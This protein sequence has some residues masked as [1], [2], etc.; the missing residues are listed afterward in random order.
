M[1]TK[2]N[3]L[4][5]ALATALVCLGFGGIVVDCAPT[6]F[7]CDGYSTCGQAGASAGTGTSGAGNAGESTGGLPSGGTDSPGG[8]AGASS[9]A[10]AAGTAPCDGKCSGTTSVCLASTSTCVECTDQSTCEAPKPACDVESNACVECTANTDC[11][12]SAKPFCDTTA[13]QCVACLK[14]ADCTSPTASACSAAGSCT[15]CTNDAE[16]A[17]I[18]GKGVCDAGTCV[19]CT[20]AKESTCAGKS[21]NPATSQCTTTPVGTVNYCQPCLA[22][23]ECIGGNQPDPDARCVPMKF[24]GTARIGGFCLKRVAK[25]CA[26]P[27]GVPISTGSL[28]GASSEAYCGIDQASTRCEA[29]LD[30]VASRA[31]PDGLATS[32]GCARNKAG[33]CTESGQGGLCQ[34]VGAFANTCTIPCG[35]SIQCTSV[36]TCPGGATPYCQ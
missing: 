10:G 22:D 16:C 24:M 21:C 17:N 19:Q 6:E 1:K 30:L 18:T 9:D 31:C 4:Q 29:V 13:N 34:T 35:N 26:P 15:A 12:E 27:F 8:A 36:T 25:T 32:C 5:R 7:G 28:S 23:S 2:R 33:A 11:E 20:V 3:S 14:Q